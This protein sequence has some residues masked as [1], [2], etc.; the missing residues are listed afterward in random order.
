MSINV[1]SCERKDVF[2]W[3]SAKKTVNNIA[4]QRVVDRMVEITELENGGKVKVISRSIDWH[5]ETRTFYRMGFFR[6]F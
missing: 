3:Q 6:F 1:L 5:D 2:E 4:I